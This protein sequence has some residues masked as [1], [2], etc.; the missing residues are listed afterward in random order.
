MPVTVTSSLL[1]LFVLDE[2]FWIVLVFSLMALACC[3]PAVPAVAAGAVA[4]VVAEDAV[5]GAVFLTAVF[6][7]LPL[8]GATELCAAVVAAAFAPSLFQ[9]AIVTAALISRIFR[10][11]GLDGNC[12]QFF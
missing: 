7:F 1:L 2:V 11:P 6:F 12:L 8:A 9:L 5:A 4:G 10:R 3:V